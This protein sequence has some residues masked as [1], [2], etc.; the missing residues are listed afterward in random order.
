MYDS[1]QTLEKGIMNET[2]KSYPKK[3]ELERS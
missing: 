1:R 2:S 3:L